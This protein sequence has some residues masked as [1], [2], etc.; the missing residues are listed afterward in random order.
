[1]G[2]TNVAD[3]HPFAC[4]R[5][6]LLARESAEVSGENARAASNFQEAS[7]ACGRTAS[8]SS[9]NRVQDHPPRLGIPP[10][11]SLDE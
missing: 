9:V 7:D 2:R 3:A 5:I 11:V 1:M 6:E 10:A 4:A 8:D